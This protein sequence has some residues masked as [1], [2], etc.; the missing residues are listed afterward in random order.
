MVAALEGREKERTGIK[1]LKV[2]YNKVFGYYIEVSKSYYDLVP[3]DYVRKQTLANCERF[4]TQE[5]KDLEHEILSA[6]SRVTALEYQLFCQLREAASQRVR[7]VQD[8]ARGVA[9]LDV[10]ASFAAA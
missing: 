9:R 1:S 8:V 10:L 6:Q 3:Q 2:R 5:L 7:Q 4:I